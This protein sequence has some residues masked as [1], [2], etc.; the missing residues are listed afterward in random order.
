MQRKA[1]KL[2]VVGVVTVATVILA[3]LPRSGLLD[4]LLTV[5]LLASLTALVGGR[6][7][8]IAA[9]GARVTATHPFE[10]CAMAAFGPLS[11]AV[12]SL[13]AVVGATAGEKKRPQAIRLAFNLGAMV[14]AI[15]AAAWIF[16]LLGG[17]TGASLLEIV[18]PL[19][20]ATAAALA[21]AVAPSCLVAQRSSEPA[22]QGVARG[23]P[24]TS[25]AGQALPGTKPSAAEP[26]LR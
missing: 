3:L 16:L 4:N 11:G 18:W 15:L 20:G 17:T 19:A 21:A 10:L 24:S 12:V 9:L 6:P 1:L 5:A 7:V 25:V 2:L 22:S 14:L 23:W 13:A 8:H 26:A